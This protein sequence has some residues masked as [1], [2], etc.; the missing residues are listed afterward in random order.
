MALFTAV[1]A[2]AGGLLGGGVTGA[3]TG[4]GI[5]MRAAG[6]FSAARGR[7]QQAE[8]A[9]GV[10][11]TNAVIAAQNARDVELRGRTA[12]YDKRRDIARALGTARAATAGA[13]LVV[14]QE[15][16]TSQEIINAMNIAGEL[17]VM[18]LY[19]NIERERRRALIQQEQFTA[20]AG[21]F[22][23]EASSINPLRSAFSTA[24]AG[25]TSPGSMDILFSGG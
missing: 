12:V 10:Q 14:D 20:Q 16:T 23:A 1:G 21:Q 19:N 2:V 5:G 7:K 22:S 17:D 11:E 18:R 24:V 8:F 3:L 9:A 6:A 4:A 13:G 15:G 25:V